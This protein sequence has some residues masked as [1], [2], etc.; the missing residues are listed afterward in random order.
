LSHTFDGISEGIALDGLIM[1]RLSK[2]AFWRLN[3]RNVSS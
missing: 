2:K 1:T 3:G